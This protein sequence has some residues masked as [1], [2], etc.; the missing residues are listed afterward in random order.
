MFVH[1]TSLHTCSHLLTQS[2]SLSLSLSLLLRFALHTVVSLTQLRVIGR[3]PSFTCHFPVTHCVVVSVCIAF[4]GFGKKVKDKDPSSKGVRPPAGSVYV[5][6]TQCVRVVRVC[7]CVCVCLFVL[8]TCAY[9]YVCV[10]VWVQ[11]LFVTHP[12]RRH[13]HTMCQ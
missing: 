10:C 12:S 7:V 6:R 8:H 13:L 2:L 11:N 4:L 5:E 1:T 9:T 3:D